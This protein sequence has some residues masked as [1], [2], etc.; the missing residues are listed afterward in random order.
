LADN[1]VIYFVYKPGACTVGGF[2]VRVCVRGLSGIT[3]KWVN[4]DGGGDFE[5]ISVVG[6]AA[7]EDEIA[8]KK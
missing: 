6:Y 5:P 8:E 2:V 3:Y 7:G 1:D 4:A